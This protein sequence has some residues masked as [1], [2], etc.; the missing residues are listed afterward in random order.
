MDII[1]NMRLVV[2]N[3]IMRM[4]L[5]WHLE[6]IHQCC[7]CPM[8]MQCEFFRWSDEPAPTG[9]RETDEQNLIR[10]ECIRLQESLNEIQQE[11]DCE[12]TEW[13]REK[14]EL[15]SQLS[16]VQFELDAL[17]KRIKMANESD[18]M[19][20]LDK[21]SIADDKD[22]DALVLHTMKLWISMEE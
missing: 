20:P 19:P 4:L 9:D 16:T 10:H 1:Y 6:R 15:T 11:L 17:K 14:S 7:V 13:G 5:R 21:L 3:N 18:L 2:S 22:D 8:E 12:R